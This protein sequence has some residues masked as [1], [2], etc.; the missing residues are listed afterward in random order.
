MKSHPYD[1]IIVMSFGG[2]EGPADVMP[3]LD[4]VLRGKNVPEERKREVAHHYDE[5][6]G[7]SPI[8]QQN[9]DL[10][11]ALHKELAAQGVD[12]PIYWGNRN[13]APYVT[14]TIREMRDKGVKRMLTLVTSGFS[15]Y[16]GCR[17]Y[18]EDVEKARQA[19]G[20]D[21]PV[22]EPAKAA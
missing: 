21:A 12:L 8:N 16:S 5:F 14:D 6:G 10:I 20:P 19:V 15:C 9:R 4:N 7:I 3:F 22:S 18:R 17:Q 13:W 1:A 2:P 11:A